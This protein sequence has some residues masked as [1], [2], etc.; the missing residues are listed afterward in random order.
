MSGEIISKALNKAFEKI[1]KAP[2]LEGL[3]SFIFTTKTGEVRRYEK[4]SSGSWLKKWNGQIEDNTLAVKLVYILS[5]KDG[6]LK[7]EKE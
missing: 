4:L 1:D 6:S 2:I 5:K 7:E 3:K